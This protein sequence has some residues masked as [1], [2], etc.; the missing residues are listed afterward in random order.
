VQPAEAP[1]DPPQAEDRLGDFGPVR[2]YCHLRMLAQW[3]LTVFSLPCH[4][5]D[6]FV[7]G[8]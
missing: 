1:A 6:R 3:K 8:G 4:G 7:H 5:S 2:G